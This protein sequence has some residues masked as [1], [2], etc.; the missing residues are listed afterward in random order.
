M[1]HWL[2]TNFPLLPYAIE[3]S[4]YHFEES[5]KVDILPPWFP[6]KWPRNAFMRNWAFMSIQ[7]QIEGLTRCPANVSLLY[8][9]AE[10][11]SATLIRKFFKELLRDAERRQDGRYGCPIIAT[12]ALNNA[13]AFHEICSSIANMLQRSNV[14]FDWSTL[15]D[16]MAA[17][18]GIVPRGAAAPDLRDMLGIYFKRDDAKRDQFE[19]LFIYRMGLNLLTNQGPIRHNSMKRTK[20]DMKKRRWYKAI[21]F[22]EALERI[23]MRDTTKNPVEYFYLLWPDQGDLQGLDP[24]IADPDPSY[25]HLAGAGDWKLVGL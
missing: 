7:L 1:K 4:W 14:D 18:E 19:D 8:V 25:H 10:T 2:S 23:E 20:T 16:K 22:L 6:A 21:K 3:N 15:N 12:V 9:F 13:E 5:A 11:N 17:F 24:T